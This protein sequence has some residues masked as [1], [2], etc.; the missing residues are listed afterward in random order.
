MSNFAA[1]IPLNKIAEFC[2]RWQIRELALFG[3]ALR[4]DFGPDSD[5][6]MLVAFAANSEW[7]LFEHV[8]MQQELETLL[9]RSVDLV[10]RRALERSPNWLRR[11]EILDTAQ[12]LFSKQEAVHAA[13]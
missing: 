12:T 4:D 11:R 2:Q 3:S 9:Q 13:G 6:D 10:S 5:V 7:G 8:Q 1:T